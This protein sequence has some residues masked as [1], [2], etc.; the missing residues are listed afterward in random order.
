M[1]QISRIDLSTL[2]GLVATASLSDNSVTTAKISD[3][4][5]TTAKISD[6]QIV[7]AKDFRRCYYHCQNH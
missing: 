4:Q 3:N 2:G 5:I 7:T 6:N 1:V